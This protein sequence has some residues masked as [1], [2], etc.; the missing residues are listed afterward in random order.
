MT[1]RKKRQK[2]NVPPGQVANPPDLGY[3]YG[4]LLGK[5]FST[6]LKVVVIQGSKQAAI[7]LPVL[8]G[9]PSVPA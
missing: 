3:F 9:F 8:S 2:R 7:I 5:R 4:A 1:W 6:L